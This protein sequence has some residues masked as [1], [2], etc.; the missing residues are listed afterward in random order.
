[1]D[2]QEMMDRFFYRKN[3]FAVKTS[4]GFYV[5][6][7]RDVTI[8]D[9]QRH[10]IGAHT[11]GAYQSREDETCMWACIDFDDHKYDE[12]AK[13]ITKHFKDHLVIED[14]LYEPSESKGSHVWFFFNI[15]TETQNAHRFLSMVL[16]TY[17]LRSGRDT[18]I[19]IFPRS[20]HLSGKRVG[21]MVRIPRS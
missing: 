4:A 14:T 12:K 8:S 17:H 13:E 10:I 20:P 1:M 15:P 16:D 18:K 5:P 3:P 6:V 9:I 2:A 7:Y 19:D 11:I 21:W